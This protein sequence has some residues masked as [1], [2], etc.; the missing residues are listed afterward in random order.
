M[1]CTVLPCNGCTVPL[2]DCR[3]LQEVGEASRWYVE[4]GPLVP[5]YATVQ[6]GVLF[7]HLVG[8][9]RVHVI[10][11]GTAM[12]S[13]WNLV[14]DLI[15][16]HP[17]SAPRHLHLTLLDL[18]PLLHPRRR[19]L[20]SFL[21]KKWYFNLLQEEAAAAGVSF[22]LDRIELQDRDIQG[23]LSGVRRSGQETVLVCTSFHLM[24]IPDTPGPGRTP[25]PRDCALEVCKP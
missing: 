24:H 2:C 8:R 6:A 3:N 9:E 23:L 17:G 4:A 10:D 15:Q 21:S 14:F 7:R 12:V 20:K 13:R 22:T 5:F 18:T 25:S 16:A 1:Y 19:S 11:L